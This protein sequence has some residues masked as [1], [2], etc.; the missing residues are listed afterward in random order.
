MKINEQDKNLFRET[1]SK[2][3]NEGGWLANLF[4]KKASKNIKKDKDIQKAIYDADKFTEKSRNKISNLFKGNKDE[5]KKALPS[6][7]LRKSLGF[8]F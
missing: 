7:D 5:I 2:W 1:H 3:L 6:K 4:I 8:D